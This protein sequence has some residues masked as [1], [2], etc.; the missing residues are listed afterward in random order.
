M[1]VL[2][3]KSLKTVRDEYE[4]LKKLLPKNCHFKKWGNRKQHFQWVN[5]IDY[6]YDSDVTVHSPLMTDCKKFL[7]KIRLCPI[8]VYGNDN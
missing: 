8:M 3:D 6:Y 1:I 4:G 7:D 2:Q 5:D